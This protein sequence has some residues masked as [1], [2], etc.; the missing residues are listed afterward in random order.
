MD[1]WHYCVL[2]HLF[3]LFPF[4]AVAFG[5]TGAYATAYSVSPTGSDSAS[6][7]RDGPLAHDP[8]RARHG[9]RRRHRHGRRRDLRGAG[10]RYGF[11]DG[12]PPRS[13]S[14]RE[15]SGAPRSRRRTAI[16]PRTSSSS[17]PAATSRSMVSRSRARRGRASPSSATRTTA[18]T[19]AAS[20]S[21]TAT[22]TTTAERPS[23]A[24]TTASFPG[25]R[26]ISRSR[27][28][29]S[30]PAASTA[31]TSRTRRTTRPSCATRFRTPAP[32]ASRSTPTS[33]RAATA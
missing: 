17:R 25:S 8:A 9:E 16:P 20:S 30:T 28:T 18:A 2:P 7:L 21:R 13:F 19:R 24:G 1:R 22:P 14:G 26:W 3:R 10:L 15:T 29:S 5:S 12:R 4:L 11:G 31:S 32:T 33:A 27:T 23:P 6:G